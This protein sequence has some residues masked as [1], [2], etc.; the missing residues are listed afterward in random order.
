MF[1]L[2]EDRR[3]PLSRHEIECCQ[4]HKKVSKCYLK[5]EDEES[6][7]DLFC[8]CPECFIEFIEQYRKEK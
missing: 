8:M 2:K 3:V 4:C 6:F 7:K 5:Q 1:K